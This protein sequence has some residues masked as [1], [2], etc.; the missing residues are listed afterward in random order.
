[1]SYIAAVLPNDQDEYTA[2]TT[3]AASGPAIASVN[4]P[5]ADSGGVRTETGP[6]QYQYVFH[7]KAPTGFDAAATHTI[8]IYGSRVLTDF[9]LGTNYASTE[10]NFVPNGS[11]VTKVH[12]VIRTESCNSCHDQLSFHGGARRGVDMCVLCHTPQM[13]D[14]DYREFCR[15][16]GHDP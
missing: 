14:T 8:G 5:S 16:Q 1:M 12:D 11:K 10:F 2:Y 15:L 7:T 3:R 6:G 4:R 13:V 9:D